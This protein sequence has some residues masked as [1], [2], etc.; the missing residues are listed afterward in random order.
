MRDYKNIVLWA[1]NCSQWSKKKKMVL[2]IM[3]RYEVNRNDEPDTITVKYLA[4]G[5]T[6][7]SVNSSHHQTEKAVKQMKNIKT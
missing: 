7:M 3:V 5:H 4:K 6:F 1:N 2:H